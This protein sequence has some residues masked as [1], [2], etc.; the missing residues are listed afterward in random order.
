MTNDML[1]LPHNRIEEIDRALKQV[2]PLY[3]PGSPSP[4]NELLR[5]N[6]DMI[7]EQGEILREHVL[8][9]LAITRITTLADEDPDLD[10]ALNDNIDAQNEL[11]A[12]AS[13]LTAATKQKNQNTIAIKGIEK[14]RHMFGV[15]ANE[16]NPVKIEFDQTDGMVVSFV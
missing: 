16:H 14:L 6:V 8:A 4:F 12:M 15:K 13:A 7:S 1:S 9:G 3:D 11:R 10:R 2:I 5:L